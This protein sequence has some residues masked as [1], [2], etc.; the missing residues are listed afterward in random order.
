MAVVKR[1]DSQPAVCKPNHQI[2][3]NWSPRLTLTR[4]SPNHS[5]TMDGPLDDDFPNGSVAVPNGGSANASIFS[6]EKVQLQFV[7]S[8]IVSFVVA[9]NILCMALKTGRIIRIDLEHP[10]DVDGMCN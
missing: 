7:V 6:I 5:A 2:T 3:N 4:V 1:K 8:N 10:Q 9:N